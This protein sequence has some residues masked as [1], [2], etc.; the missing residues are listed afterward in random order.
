MNALRK[1][2]DVSTTAATQMAPMPVVVLSVIALTVMDILAMVYTPQ[3][4]R[5][6]LEIVISLFDRRQ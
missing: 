6:L 5:H 1:F 3:C 4:L 2:T